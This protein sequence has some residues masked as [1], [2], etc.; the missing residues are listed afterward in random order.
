MTNQSIEIS[1][2]FSVSRSTLY[3]AWTDEAA[4]KEWWKPMGKSLVEMEN[5][6]QEGGKVAYVFE[7]LENP[8]G[9]LVIQGVYQTAIPEEKLVYTWNWVLD[10]IA[11][12]NA[13]YTLT[14]EFSEQNEGTELRVQQHSEKELEGLQPHKAGWEDALDSLDNYLKV[15]PS[16]S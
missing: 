7:D 12:E 6:V 13:N 4:L 16:S 15:L 8:T 3:K 1:K 14:V 5:E 10:D 9:R 2:N 11:V